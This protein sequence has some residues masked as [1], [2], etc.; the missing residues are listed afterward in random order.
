MF[1]GPSEKVLFRAK[2]CGCTYRS[3]VVYGQRSAGR[4]GTYVTRIYYV[5][6]K[7][8]LL[9]LTKTP[10]APSAAYIVSSFNARRDV[11]GIY[12][13]NQVMSF[14]YRYEAVANAAIR[15]TSQKGSTATSLLR[16]Q[17]QKYLNNSQCSRTAAGCNVSVSYVRPDVLYSD[18]KSILTKVSFRPSAF[19]SWIPP[20]ANNS[21]KN[22]FAFRNLK[23][24]EDGLPIKQ[25]Y[26]IVLHGSVT[27]QSVEA[28]QK[29]LKEAWGTNNKD[30]EP[31]DLSVFV[32][33]MDS[34]N[35]IITNGSRVTI[36]YYVV[37]VD[38]ADASLTIAEEPPV[39]SIVT[40]F[41][42]MSGGKFAVCT[43]AVS[44]QQNI[45]TVGN[46]NAANSTHLEAVKKALEDAWRDANKDFTG[47]ITV[48]VHQVAKNES[49]E[50]EQTL[51]FSINPVGGQ[52]GV[53]DADF[54][55]PSG[56]MLQ[57]RFSGAD[58]LVTLV[59][60]GETETRT[61][62]T[63]EFP[64]YIPVGVILALLLIF[65]IIFVFICIFRDRRKV[66]KEID[67]NPDDFRDDN[68]D[69]EHFTME[70]VAFDNEAFRHLEMTSQ[71][72][73]VNPDDPDNGPF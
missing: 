63:E 51:T 73:V 49:R 42:K 53:T 30:I 39:D 25:Q 33:K 48:N 34:E 10:E 16:S 11:Y 15:L 3:Q 32:I 9:Q 55:R 21:F 69:K 50:N 18:V 5:I 20:K 47:N 40:A 26:R 70:P 71:S 37:V 31:E 29:T 7:N 59:Q 64:W 38:Q 45:T 56:S 43:C 52:S 2:K 41:N 54:K 44:R 17:W 65:V 27:N 22:V 61:G 58:T 35:F 62:Q 36:V 19:N 46:L 1:R 24:L 60:D 72:Y 68:Y 66:S 12:R 13:H 67:N 6:Y 14:N 57:T 8:D 28:V 4:Y 23:V